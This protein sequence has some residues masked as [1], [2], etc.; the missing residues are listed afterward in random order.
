MSV[1]KPVD[2]DSVGTGFN[3][4]GPWTGAVSGDQRHG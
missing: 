3:R 2:I 4:S 1:P